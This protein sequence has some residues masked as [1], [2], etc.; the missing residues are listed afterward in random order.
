MPGGELGTKFD[1]MRHPT[2]EG[3]AHRSNAHV[4]RRFRHA[5]GRVAGRPNDACPEARRRGFF[6]AASGLRSSG[7]LA[8]REG[9]HVPMP[10]SDDGDVDP[11]AR[12]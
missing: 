6:D 1:E 11:P 12:L 5:N 9:H 10:L 2:T 3:E 8:A 4:F 7:A